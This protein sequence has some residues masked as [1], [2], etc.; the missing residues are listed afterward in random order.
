M[1]KLNQDKLKSF[2]PRST[3]G[4]NF[5]MK[6]VYSISKVF[7]PALVIISSTITLDLKILAMKMIDKQL[8][9]IN[10]LCHFD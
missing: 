10:G 7:F 5:E 4:Y 8:F 2:Y 3:I 1:V 9:I 6:I